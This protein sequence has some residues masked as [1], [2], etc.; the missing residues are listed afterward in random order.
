MSIACTLAALHRRTYTRTSQQQGN[1][2]LTN[3]LGMCILGSYC[4]P[5]HQIGASPIKLH[6]LQNPSIIL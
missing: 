4:A 1:C 3:L 6:V 5:M 2:H